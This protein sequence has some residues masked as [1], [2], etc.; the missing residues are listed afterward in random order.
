MVVARFRADNTW[1]AYCFPVP[2]VNHDNEEHLWESL[3]SQLPENVAREMFG[4]LE[5]MPYSN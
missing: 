2:G 4:F 1:K 3:G 5:N